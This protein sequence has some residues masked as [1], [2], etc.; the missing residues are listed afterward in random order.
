MGKQVDLLI[1]PYETDVIWN[2]LLKMILFQ[3]NPDLKHGEG[4][5]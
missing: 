3:S 2:S 4:T 5:K 1:D